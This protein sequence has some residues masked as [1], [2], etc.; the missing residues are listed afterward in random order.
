MITDPGS[1][2]PP[3]PAHQTTVELRPGLFFQY[4]ATLNS[5]V[6]I[7]ANSIPIALATPM[8]NGA[9]AAVDLRKLNRLVIPPPVS[10]I[11]GT[12]C[13]APFQAGNIGLFA[14]DRFVGV[15]GTVKIQNINTVGAR[16]SVDLPFHV[17]Q[18]TYAF[19]FTIDFP[20]LIS[21]L[22]LRNQFNITGKTGAVGLPGD[23]GLVG[24]DSILSG[25]PGDMGATGSAPPCALGIETDN[26]QVAPQ[27]GMTKAL[28][29][30]HV[31]LNS[32]DST[33]YQLVFDRQS[34]GPVGFAA[35][36]F[37]VQT[38]TSSWVLAITGN[39]VDAPIVDPRASVECGTFS[40][41]NS[42]PL[43]Y[44]DMDPI[45]AAVHQQFLVE[46]Q[47][48]H[49][50]YENIVKFWIQVMSDLFDE[51]KVALCCALEH[52][53][54][55]TKNTQILQHIEDVA[56]AAAGSANILL[57]NRTSNEA[58]NLSSTRTLSEDLCKGGPDFP[59]Y[60]NVAGGG[61]GGFGPPPPVAPAA[62]N[63][64]LIT[65]DPLLH[66]SAVTAKQVLLP[67][68]DYTATIDRVSALVD[69]KHRANLK[70]QYLD[71]NGKRVAHFL[72]KGAFATLSDARSAYEG[73]SL[74]FH[75]EGG[76]LGLWLPGLNLRRVSGIIE[77]SIRPAADP[78][79]IPTPVT[80]LVE[81]TIV[82]EAVAEPTEPT[83]YCQMSTTHLAWY[84]RGW[85]TGNCCG[86]IMNIMGHN[87]IIVKR[88]VGI[89]TACGGGESDTEP[90]IM[91]F[92]KTSRGHPAF[93]WPTFD[94]KTFAPL[95]DSPAVTFQFD[96]VLN[97]IIAQKINAGDFIEGRG[98]PA[99]IR[100][101]TFQ[102]MTVLFPVG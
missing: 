18:H 73:L 19:D 44:V 25:P 38:D 9:M 85:Q 49:T 51:Q 83:N 24:P 36:T 1:L 14:G 45:V 35:E 2:F 7:T 75:H 43:Y 97:D 66:S 3:T 42:Q 55:Q 71:T 81:P 30:G 101:L 10:S 68:G 76:M 58:V 77:V 53:L 28:V 4:D 47:L 6:K 15:D 89:D 102:L 26:L 79:L 40:A 99:G 41:G 80:K 31:V 52:C 61:V 87:Y 90:C 29:D 34:I 57:H 84:E 65:V 12:D 46:A 54:S 59:Q 20:E 37:H 78:I 5:W 23:P 11:S 50:S 17:H 70:L 93:A 62:V 82:A 74:S 91:K 72:D 39:A 69:S 32:V 86:L 8:A 48:I 21:E 96:Q 27:I 13:I 100:H 95:P 88:S 22:K 33:K 67:A 16:V 56:G 60:P 63:P 64:Q 98:F 92:L 94:S